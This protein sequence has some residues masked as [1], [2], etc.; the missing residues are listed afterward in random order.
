MIDRKTNLDYL[1]VCLQPPPSLSREIRRIGCIGKGNLWS[2]P[3]ISGSYAQFRP[4]KVIL[5]SVV[6]GISHG[7]CTAWQTGGLPFCCSRFLR[8]SS[9]YFPPEVSSRFVWQDIR[10]TSGYY[11]RFPQ[12]T[13]WVHS[14]LQRTH[15][16]LLKKL[17]NPQFKK[18]LKPKP[19]TDNSSKIN[20]EMWTI[21]TFLRCWNSFD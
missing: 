21:D 7:A 18:R 5:I 2:R 19:K 11:S 6:R 1:F 3:G 16:A 4:F 10:V 13:S 14:G 12:W 9:E 20:F 17:N 15:N 8:W